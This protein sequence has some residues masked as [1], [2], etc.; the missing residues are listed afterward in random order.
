MRSQLK[1]ELLKEVKQNGDYAMS[2]IEMMLKNAADVTL[3]CGTSSNELTIMNPDGFPTAFTCTEG[4][5]IASNS[6]S[7]TSDKVVIYNCA[8]A[9]RVVCPA[10]AVSPKYV[11]V[12]FKIQQAGS[13]L[14]PTPGS[15]VSLEYQTTI[16]LRKYE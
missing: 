12:A 13:G 16:S 15:T 6:Q 3:G 5:K 1:S 7:L 8:N 2:V 4:D 10:P 14:M 9:F 11:F